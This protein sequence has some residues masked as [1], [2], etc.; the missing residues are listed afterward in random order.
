MF[1]FI[2]VLFNLTFAHGVEC[3][4]IE[5]CYISLNNYYNLLM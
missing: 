2:L 1:V 3:G 4:D 5:K